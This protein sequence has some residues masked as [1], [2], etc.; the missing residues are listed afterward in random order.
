M[1]SSLND[2]KKQAEIL[3]LWLHCKS[4]NTPG[5]AF[6]WWKKLQSGKAQLRCENIKVET[7]KNNFPF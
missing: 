5:Q 3:F 7:K 6:F 2:P 4:C 1:F